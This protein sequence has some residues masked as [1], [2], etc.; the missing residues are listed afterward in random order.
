MITPVTHKADLLT[1]PRQGGEPDHAAVTGPTAAGTQPDSDKTPSGP[2][3]RASFDQAV[4]KVSEILKSTDTRLK[5][6]VDDATKRVVVK[7]LKGDSE[8][9]IRQF[10]PKEVLQLAKYLSGSKGVLLQEQA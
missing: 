9:I 7:I 4:A 2:I 8:E 10:P 5:I 1:T 6:E 3:D